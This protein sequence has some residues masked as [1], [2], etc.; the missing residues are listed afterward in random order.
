MVT[1]TPQD[2]HSS[3]EPAPSKGCTKNVLLLENGC[4][5]SESAAYSE[6]C[7]SELPICARDERYVQRRPRYEANKV[8]S[9][10]SKGYGH[11]SQRRGKSEGLEQ[12]GSWG[13][14]PRCPGYKGET[15]GSIPVAQAVQLQHNPELRPFG[16]NVQPKAQGGCSK[17][18]S[19]ASDGW[20]G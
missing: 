14:S 9:A 20:S 1:N 5:M 19:A 13:T 18:T 11:Q 12:W 16:E 7:S 2:H 15:L 17:R 10:Q 8:Q 3:P 6:R 4:D